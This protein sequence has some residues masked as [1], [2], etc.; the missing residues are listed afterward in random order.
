[1]QKYLNYYRDVQAQAKEKLKTDKAK[2]KRD[3]MVAIMGKLFAENQQGVEDIIKIHN[4]TV[5][6]KNQILKKINSVQATKQF[7]KTDQGY[8]VTNPEGY[9]AIDSD[10]QAVKLVDRL[11]FSRANLN[12]QKQ[13]AAE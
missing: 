4:Q 10:G 13:W 8:K 6:L 2:D 11:D 3:Q 1:M 9:V 12:A 7:I 5:I